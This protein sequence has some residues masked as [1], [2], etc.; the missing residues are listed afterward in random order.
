MN[1]NQAFEILQRAGGLRAARIITE[2]TQKFSKIK[3]HQ[4]V[5]S[6]LVY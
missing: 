4:L 1:V 5:S 6:V 2:N 3:K